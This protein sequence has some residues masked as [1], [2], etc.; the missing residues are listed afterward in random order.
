[1]NHTDRSECRCGCCVKVEEKTEEKNQWDLVQL[2]EPPHTV[3]V[4]FFDVSAFNDPTVEEFVELTKEHQSDLTEDVN[5][6]D[7]LEH[8]YMELGA[9]I[10]DQGVAMQ[11]MALG[12][13]LG[14][15]KVMHPGKILNLN[16][17]REKQLADQL[18]GAGMI[19][20]LPT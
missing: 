17:P 14:L 20:I 15:W 3:N 16:N 4:F 6:L 1:M 11:Y 18:A 10:G 13:I 8:S 5:P 7:G 19:S 2:V 12:E 9:W